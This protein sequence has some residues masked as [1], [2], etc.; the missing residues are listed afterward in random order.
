MDI[1]FYT[2]WFDAT[3][4]CTADDSGA[5][6]KIY[7]INYLHCSCYLSQTMTNQIARFQALLNK[8]A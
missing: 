2:F 6:V 4:N 1:S 3:G 7:N 8:I 5:G